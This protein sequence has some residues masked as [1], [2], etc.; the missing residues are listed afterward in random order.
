[1]DRPRA[2]ARR[3]GQKQR[4]VIGSAIP[5]VIPRALQHRCEGPLL[6][7]Y[8]HSCSIMVSDQLR[9][10]PP[11]RERSPGSDGPCAETL[12]VSHLVDLILVPAAVAAAENVTGR[13]CASSP[14]MFLKA[15]RFPPPSKS[16]LPIFHSRSATVA[17]QCETNATLW[18]ADKNREWIECWW[19]PPG[20]HAS[21]PNP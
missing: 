6:I 20:R 17:T 3:A 13:A 21:N 19:S 9:L 10:G 5:N 11:K 14:L 2:A 18:W 15:G 16:S 1:M 12:P 8:R 7:A 4:L